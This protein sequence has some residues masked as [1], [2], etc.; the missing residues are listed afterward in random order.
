MNDLHGV[1]VA[2][3]ATDYYADPVPGWSLSASGAGLLLAPSCQARYL[4]ER[5]NP[6]PSTLDQEDGTL[7]HAHILGVGAQPEAYPAE[8]LSGEPPGEP[9]R[10]RESR[11][12]ISAA[13][14]ND[15]L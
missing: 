12:C 3:P 5:Q 4:H 9:P 6:T 15:R 8:V 10:C 11:T 2:M 14:A 1:H 7:A 13:T